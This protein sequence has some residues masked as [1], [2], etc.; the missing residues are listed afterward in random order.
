MP[1]EDITRDALAAVATA[2][3]D[4]RSAL[5]GTVDQLQGLLLAQ[6]GNEDQGLDRAASELG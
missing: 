3:D 6:S 4:Y 2:R 1:S 5:V